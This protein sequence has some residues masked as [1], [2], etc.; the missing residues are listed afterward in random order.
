MESV[1]AQTKQVAVN[2]EALLLDAEWSKL[3]KSGQKS[4]P[5]RRSD[6]LQELLEEAGVRDLSD[7]STTSPTTCG[8]DSK[9]VGVRIGGDRPGRFRDPWDV[10]PR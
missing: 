2:A 4:M 7:Y 6:E 9:A 3:S 5:T 1:F 10:T 8:R